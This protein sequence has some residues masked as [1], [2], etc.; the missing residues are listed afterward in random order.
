MTADRDTLRAYNW[1]AIGEKALDW[2]KFYGIVN[3]AQQQFG[4]SALEFIGM[5]WFLSN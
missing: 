1:S 3:I 2:K 4:I 5:D